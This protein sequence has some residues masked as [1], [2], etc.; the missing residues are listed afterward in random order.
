ME[1][2]DNM[3][4][5]LIKILNHVALLQQRDFLYLEAPKA[6]KAILKD[7]QKAKDLKWILENEKRC[8]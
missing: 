1:I 3:R 5:E 7:Q 6:G 4:R 2:T 8:R